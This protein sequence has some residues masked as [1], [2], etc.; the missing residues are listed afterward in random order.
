MSQLQ[1]FELHKTDSAGNDDSFSFERRQDL[2]HVFEADLNR[3]HSG[4]MELLDDTERARAARFMFEKD[5][6]RF[7][8]SHALTRQVIANCLECEPASVEFDT[9][10]HGKPFLVNAPEEMRFNISHTSDRVVIAIAWGQEVGIDIEKHRP[11]EALELAQRFFAPGEVLDLSSTPPHE[12]LPS[13]FRCWTRKEAFVKAI[14]KGLTLPLA[15]FRVSIGTGDH[16]SLLLDCEFD[17]ELLEKVRIV[18]LP[19][20]AGYSAALA[21]GTEPW[22]VVN[23]RIEY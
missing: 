5:R 17:R 21:A 16:N 23:W 8:I 20:P 22:T 4:A 7:A 10:S 3:P 12:Q 14:G 2:V 9:D 15:Q 6:N 13:F 11:V 19:A 18:D 1:N